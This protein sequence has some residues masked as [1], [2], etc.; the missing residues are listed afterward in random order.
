MFN[1]SVGKFAQPTLTKFG[2]ITSRKMREVSPEE[3]TQPSLDDNVVSNMNNAVP[4]WEILNITEDE[5]KIQ[6]TVTPITTTL[7]DKLAVDELQETKEISD[8]ILKENANEC[9]SE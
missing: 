8:A 9:G 5:Y 1:Q 3:W 7:Q 6:Y 4:I 2:N